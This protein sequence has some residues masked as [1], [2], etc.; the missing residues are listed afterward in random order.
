MYEPDRCPC[1]A[2]C[3]P[4]TGYCRPCEIARGIPPALRLSPATAREAIIV[5]LR[6]LDRR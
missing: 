2:T 1:G 5:A 3:E 4:E 6:D